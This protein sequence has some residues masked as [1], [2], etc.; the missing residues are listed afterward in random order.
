[1]IINVGIGVHCSSWATYNGTGYLW[2]HPHTHIPRLGY[3]EATHQHDKTSWLNFLTLYQLQLE[4]ILLDLAATVN[5]ARGSVLFIY[6]YLFAHWVIYDHCCRWKTKLL[7]TRK[8]A[9]LVSSVNTI[10]TP[11]WCQRFVL[12]PMYHYCL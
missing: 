8:Q 6:Y 5:L 2:V 9:N 12:P 4:A 3:S 10:C 11:H 1:M 7:L